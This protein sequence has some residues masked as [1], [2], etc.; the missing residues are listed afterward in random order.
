MKK[1]IVIV[2]CLFA[3]I[4]FTGCTPEENPSEQT[5]FTE[6]INWLNEQYKDNEI[7]ENIILSDKYQDAKLRWTSKNVEVISNEGEI[8]PLTEDEE[9]ILE[10]EITIGE[11][12]KNHQ[13]S[14]VVDRKSVV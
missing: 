9:V 13:L 8:Y 11:T 4:L 10:C 5:T 3:L 7:S 6:V 2:T 12:S 1:F 14:F